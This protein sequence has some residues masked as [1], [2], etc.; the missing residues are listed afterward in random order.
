MAF[1]DISN[2]KEKLVNTNKKIKDRQ[3]RQPETVAINVAAV[4]NTKFIPYKLSLLLPSQLKGFLT[5][6]L[7]LLLLQSVLYTQ[8]FLRKDIFT[9]IIEL[10]PPFTRKFS[11]REKLFCDFNYQLPP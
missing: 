8:W 5:S 7:L 11:T 9:H 1:G 3:K 4:E 6:L 2:A 10:P